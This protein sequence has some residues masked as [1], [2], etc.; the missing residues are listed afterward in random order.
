[1]SW[2][3]ALDAEE[4]EFLKDGEVL[5]ATYDVTVTD[6]HGATATQQ[7]TVTIVG[8]ND[9]PVIGGTSSDTV[10][11]DVDVSSGNLTAGGALTIADVDAGQSTLPAAG[12]RGRHLR[13]VHAR[14]AGN[15]TYTADNSQAAIQGLAV[16]E[17]LTDSFTAV[18]PDGTASQVVTVTI[19]GANDVVYTVND[20]VDPSATKLGAGTELHR[21][22]RHSRQ[23]LRAGQ[24]D[25]R[26][27]R[28]RPAGDL[29]PGPDGPQQRRLR[30]RRAALHGQRRAAVDGQRLA[31]QQRSPA[32][33]GASTTRSRPGSTARPPTSTT[34]PSSCSIDVDPT[35]GVSYR[36]LTLE[37]GGTGSSGYQWRDQGTGTVFIADD[38]G[39]A[40]VTQNSQNYAFAFFQSFL[41]GAYGPGNNFDGPAAVRHRAGGAPRRQLL[42]D[43]HIVVDVVDDNAGP[44]AVADTNAADAVTE[45]GVNPGNT[46]FPGDPS[47]TGNVLTNDTDPDAGDTKTVQGVAAGNVGG[48]LTTGVGGAIVG[49]TAR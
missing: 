19:N 26:R 3:F 13:H 9:V 8:T 22:L 11:E 17:S 43:N 30:R 28:A 34:S 2:N 39:N 33:R 41:T 29:P 38:A 23:R 20:T 18:S 47:A 42:A 24:P 16:D 40:N 31:G 14:C 12:V 15:W 45:S 35:A 6:N 4:A 27:R 25:R 44:T 37:P 21:R 7:V 1:M 5:D 10:Q 36:T 32:R 49:P 46:P 48:T